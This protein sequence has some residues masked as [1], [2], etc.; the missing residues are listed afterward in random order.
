VRGGQ[1]HEL[2]ASPEDTPDGGRVKY[3]CRLCGEGYQVP[4]S[5]PSCRVRFLEH[6][7]ALQTPYASMPAVARRALLDQLIRRQLTWPRPFREAMLEH[8]DR[9]QAWKTKLA[10]QSRS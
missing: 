9:W 3:R 10:T 7:E 8:F 4:T 6:M 1:P 2:V 5:A